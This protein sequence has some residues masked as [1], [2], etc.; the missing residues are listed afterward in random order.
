MP[1]QNFPNQDQQFKRHIAFKMRIGEILS[2]KPI[3]NEEKFKVLEYQDKKIVRVNLIANVIDKFIQ[4]NEKKYATLTLDDA[5]G[6]ITLRAFGDDISKFEKFIQGDTIQTIGLLRYWSNELYIIPEIIKK[7]E[8][9]YLLV[10]K[11]ELD[12]EKPKTLEQPELTA[13][14]DKII[15]IIKREE[16]NSGAE[17]EQMIL[18]LKEEPSIINQE[19]KRLLE[20]GIVYE[21]RPGKVRYLG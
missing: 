1:D 20:D 21:P 17:I 9:Q 10:R 13:L 8:P 16:T 5:S 18:E 2:G 15:N 7:R 3:L 12:I 11:L 4:D 19:I 6:Q 14:K